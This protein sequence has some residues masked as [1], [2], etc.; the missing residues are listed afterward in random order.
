ME[1]NDILEP[2]KLFKTQVQP[3]H[4]ENCETFFDNLVKESGIDIE[5]NRLTNK[6]INKANEDIENLSKSIAKKRGA[7]TALTVFAIIF[8]VVA[9]V[10]IYLLFDGPENPTI[11]PFLKIII[12]VVLIG[13]GVFFL[14]ICGIKLK[15]AIEELENSLEKLTKERDALIA[16]AKIQMMPLHELFDWDMS[17]KIFNQTIPLIQLDPVFD[18][19]R[20]QMLHDKYGFNGN[21][22]QNVSTVFCQSGTILGNSFLFEKNYVRQIIQKRYDGSLTIHWTTTYTDSEGHIHT[23]HHSETLHAS[24]YKPAPDYYYESWLVY[25]NDA[26][27]HLSFSRGPSDANHMNEKQIEKLVKSYEK[28]L[29]KMTQ[30]SIN[31]GSNFQ[32]LGNTQFEALFNA[33]DRD[34]NVEFRLLFTPLAQKNLIN[35]ITNK[36]PYGDDFTFIK[37]KNLN[38]IKSGHSQNTNY[39]CDPERFMF[40]DYDKTREYFI[41]Y[42]MNFMQS[43]YYDLA[44][45][46]SIPLYQQHAAQEYIYDGTFSRN[47]TEME[48]E[49][50]ANTYNESN[51]APSK[52]VTP[53]ILKTELL[54]KGEEADLNRVHAYSY[55]TIPHTDYVSVYGGDGSWHD[56]PVP[57]LEY[58]AIE[59]STDFVVQKVEA[60]KKQYDN[61]YRNG[62]VNEFLSHFK[63]GNDIIYKKGFVSFLGSN[64]SD[65]KGKDFNKLLNKKG[66]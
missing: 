37:I 52:A 1:I 66:E 27:P 54:Q 20:F 61:N 29:D 7:K 26:A 13:L 41:Q 30:D 3:A 18:E 40:Y 28:K 9:A 32:R 48:T 64:I 39:D 6:K 58:V 8:F 4:K 24:V 23:E 38:Y 57:W 21:P 22:E 65:Y 43:F 60:S 44:P 34:N 11:P 33:L 42:N 19:A 25:G 47:V 45:L 2:S 59:K 51:F 62:F 12:S 16:E 36:E 50:L 55:Y 35:L 49:V 15:P 56:V 53:C 17:S 31:N 46:M 63:T 14:I 5:A 10:F